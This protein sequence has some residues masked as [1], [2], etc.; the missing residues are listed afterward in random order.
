MILPVPAAI[1][2]ISLLSIFNILSYDSKN[3]PVPSLNHS[4]PDVN[5]PL[6]I[7]QPSKN[8]LPHVSPPQSPVKVL[9]NPIEPRRD[10]TLRYITATVALP[11]TGSDE[12]MEKHDS[13]PSPE[14]VA[15][16]KTRLVAGEDDSDV[17]LSKNHLDKIVAVSISS[18]D[19]S[20]SDDP[21]PY[22][23]VNIE[24]F[25]GSLV[26]EVW[27]G[28]ATLPLPSPALELAKRQG[29]LEKRHD[30]HRSTKP[31]P[32][33]NETEAERRAHESNFQVKLKFNDDVQLVLARE[34]WNQ[35]FSRSKGLVFIVPRTGPQSCNEPA[36][37]ETLHGQERG[38]LNE[39]WI[40]IR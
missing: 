6:P 37:Y 22:E 28:N 39:E 19:F 35:Q 3:P 16:A 1:P 11:A 33:K 7:V 25:T 5:D 17:D 2:S 15:Y 29:S 27:C 12:H 4:S 20:H 13:H 36:L 23:F 31:Q 18:G 32:V 24:A 34:H 9:T 26:S 10:A 38:I 30:C 14:R 21:E 8:L 40:A